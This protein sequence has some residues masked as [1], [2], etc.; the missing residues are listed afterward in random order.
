MVDARDKVSVHLSS[1]SRYNS[2]Q[3]EII[4][5][6]DGN[7]ILQSKAGD[8][9]KTLMQSNATAPLLKENEMRFFWIDIEKDRIAFGS[10]EKVPILTTS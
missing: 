2:I 4:L 7:M 9:N 3:Y 6:S 5:A 10:G 1:D 8:Q